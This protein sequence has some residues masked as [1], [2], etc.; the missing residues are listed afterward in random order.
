MRPINCG[1]RC[2]KGSLFFWNL[3]PSI[4]IPQT[5]IHSLEKIMRRRSFFR[6]ATGFNESKNSQW[7]EKAFSPTSTMWQNAKNQNKEALCLKGSLFF[8]NLVPSILIPQTLIHSLE[9][10]M[11]RRSFFRS[12]TGFNESKNSR[13]N[14]K[15]FSPAST[16]WQ[17]AK[18]QNKEALTWSM[19]KHV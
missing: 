17:N 9:K 4:L 14:E 2:L 16:M 13:R 1:F 7:N 3:V 15:A 12:A 6:S 18:N 11:R 10:I 19:M 8:W 5:L